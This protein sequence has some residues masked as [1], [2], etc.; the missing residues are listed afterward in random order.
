M[1]LTT[2]KTA[3]LCILRPGSRLGDICPNAEVLSYVL[4]L[5][6]VSTFVLIGGIAPP[7]AAGPFQLASTLGPSQPAPAGADGDSRTPIITPD[8]RYVLFAS[9]AQNLVSAASNAPTSSPHPAWFNVFLRDRTNGT[10]T[11]VS[12]NLAG[13]GGNGDSLPVTLSTNG[14][15]ALF[16]SSA[17]DL[18]PADTNNAT[19]VFVRDLLNGNTLLVSA[20]TNGGVADGAS[21]N[22]AMTPDGRYVAFVSAADNLVIGD[23]NGIPD[24]FVRD[25]VLGTNILVS[26]GAVT[27]NATYY[28]QP[29]SSE[30]PDITPDGRYVVFQSGAA[31][32]VP[33]VAT[34][35]EIYVRDLLSG[36][37][38]LASVDARA[39]LTAAQNSSAGVCYNQVISTNGQFVA[40][41]ISQGIGAGVVLRYNSASGLSDVLNTNA[42]APMG[43]YEDIH[44]LDMTP[45]GQ[46]V[47]FLANT[48]GTAGMTT[49]LYVWNATSGTATLASGDLSNAVQTNSQVAWPVLDAGGQFVEFLSNATNLVTNSIVGPYHLYRHDLLS[50]STLL[51]NAD[52]NG[53]GSSISPMAVPSLSTG[54]LLATFDAADGSL[55]ANDRNHASDVFVRDLTAGANE[56]VSAH[57]AGMST[58]T[59]NG[60]S[61]CSAA[62]ISSNSQYLVFASEADNLVPNDTNA[63]RDIFARNLTAGTTLLVSVATNGASG[64]DLSSQPTLSPDGRYV[65]F[66]SKA[67]DLVDGDANEATDVFLRDLQAGT[68]L[69]V[70]L[71]SS[72]T[73]PG[74][75]DSYA[76]IVGTGGRFVVFRS[77]AGNL[78]AGTFS[79]ENLFVRDLQ[80]GKTYALTTVG[81]SSPSTSP[82][83]RFVAYLDNSTSPARLYLWDSTL[84]KTVYTNFISGIQTTA[85]SP[86]GQRLVF[87]TTTQLYNADRTAH[88]NGSFLA[89]QPPPS[90]SLRLSGDGHLLTYNM[91]ASGVSQVYCYDFSAG[92]N[93]LVSR[94]IT[95]SGGGN[96]NS[97]SPVISSNGRFVAYRSLAT[98]LTPGNG[99]GIANVFLFDRQNGA[100]TLLSASRFGT[101]PANGWSSGPVFSGDSQ[102]LVFQSWASDLVAQD[103][104]QSQ[105]VFAYNLYY[106][107]AIP[108]F[109]AQIV[110]GSPPGT[111]PLLVWPALPGKNYQVQFKNNVTDANWQLLN[112]DVTIMG[113]Q[114]CFTDPSPAPDKRFY[115]IVAY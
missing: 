50:G 43:A 49:S 66:A 81:V 101:S 100:T 11:L 27:S 70:S 83:A 110:P 79:G 67:D 77:I 46:L 85:I 51:V 8:G 32:L 40:Y 47:A 26:V 10:T 89:Y 42:A 9:T 84:A 14:Q 113:D 65:A 44:T 5:L 111:G 114:G 103:F 95:N 48:N 73:G 74:N 105:D 33:G 59:P 92:T 19:D 80:A 97:D 35:G 93:L 96:A 3:A 54:G 34:V 4:R 24:V 36:T 29:S 22:P 107:G 108:V 102:T 87:S 20:S 72:G 30:A 71:N 17:S 61:L 16:V 76:P 88:T 13:T 64:E 21:R 69:L 38:I 91:L 25:L 52:T 115:R 94:S 106:S 68:T 56:L 37:T 45:D 112:A 58:V 57:A 1:K 86:D 90:P 15:Y 62:C 55:T 28:L 12:V 39:A 99:G 53:A 23:T 104:N 18:V 109:L 82:D 63:C 98:D 31:G 6:S 7:A 60:P 78:A 75:K 2:H 41:E